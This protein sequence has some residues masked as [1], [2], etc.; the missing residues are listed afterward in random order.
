MFAAEN[1]TVQFGGLV[2][3]NLSV[4]ETIRHD[5]LR[6]ELLALPL[7]ALVVF[8][9]FGSPASVALLLAA[10]TCGIV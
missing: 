1:L 3:T 2:P 5:L 9:V 8:L 6:A 4:F 7:V 10:G